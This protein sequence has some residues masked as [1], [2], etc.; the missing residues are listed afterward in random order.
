MNLM[1]V[2]NPKVHYIEVVSGLNYSAHHNV[3]LRDAN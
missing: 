3:Y 2:G 1:S